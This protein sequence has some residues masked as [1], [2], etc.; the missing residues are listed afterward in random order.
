MQRHG[1]GPACSLG[2]RTSGALEGTVEVGAEAGACPPTN[3]KAPGAPAI[4]DTGSPA[5]EA[6][7]TAPG[8]SAVGW[9]CTV[10]SDSGARSQEHEVG[11]ATRVGGG[12]SASSRTSVRALDWGGPSP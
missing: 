10:D 8:G 7:S 6:L 9:G 3:G 5:L 1:G 4:W 12:A 2:R 11:A